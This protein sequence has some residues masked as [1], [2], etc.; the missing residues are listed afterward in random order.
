MYWLLCS[1]NND[2]TTP[3]SVKLVFIMI[4]LYIGKLNTRMAM[5]M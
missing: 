5:Q 4:I 2:K 1:N 3:L